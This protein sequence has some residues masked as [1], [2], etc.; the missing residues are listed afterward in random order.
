[1]PAIPFS[2]RLPIGRTP[3]KAPPMPPRSATAY[4]TTTERQV[5]DVVSCRC[6]LDTQAGQTDILHRLCRIRRRHQL[7]KAAARS[8][9]GHMPGR[10]PQIAMPQ[11][12]GLTAMKKIRTNDIR[13]ST[14]NAA[15]PTGAGS[16]FS[17][18]H[19]TESIGAKAWHNPAISMTVLRY[20]TILSV[21]YGV[22]R[23]VT[24]Q[25]F[26]RVPAATWRRKILKRRYQ[27]PTAYAKAFRI[28][29]CVLVYTRR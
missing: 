1:M 17:N 27:W 11:P 15:P 2:N 18:I 19:P 22:F 7:G 24:A 13:C 3:L 20:S 6:R 16:L 21:E 5:Q 26:H 28:K 8:G 9:K 10:A 4:G 25:R 29:C 14:S 23:C 12:Y